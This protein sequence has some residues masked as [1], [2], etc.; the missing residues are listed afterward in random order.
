MVKNKFGQMKIQQMAFM[1]MAVTLFFILVGMFALVWRFAGIKETATELEEK[2]AM[3]LAT[4]LANSPEFSC[5]NSFGTSKLSCIDADK[6]I[7]LKKNINKYS[8]FWGAGVSNIKIEIIYP[9]TAR[10][11]CTIGNYPD[12][13]IIDLFEQG[14][15]GVATWNYVNVCRKAT[16]EQG[17][18]D[19]CSLGKLYV[20]TSEEQE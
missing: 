5:G 19:K 17:I 12:C 11:D 3:L 18:Y 4:K 1:L 16:D 7:N 2:N 13:N 9:V 15:Q 6:V 8:G 10:K 14:I 20:Y